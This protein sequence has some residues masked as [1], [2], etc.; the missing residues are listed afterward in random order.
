MNAFEIMQRHHNALESALQ[1]IVNLAPSAKKATTGKV[2][3]L[4]HLRSFHNILTT[5]NIYF[6]KQL[7]CSVNLKF[8]GW[9]R[10]WKIIIHKWQR[11]QDAID[12][13]SCIGQAIKRGTRLRYMRGDNKDKIVMA[14][15][16]SLEDQKY[17]GISDGGVVNK[18]LMK[19][20]TERETESM[21]VAQAVETIANWNNKAKQCDKVSIVNGRTVAFIGCGEQKRFELNQKEFDKEHFSD[22]LASK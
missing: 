11:T 4:Q 16:D 10:N 12:A 8:T 1:R 19:I 21:K 18:L 7:I 22:K 13:G 15:K 14:R 5:T 20:V 3:E 17:V 6:N 9:D 2:I